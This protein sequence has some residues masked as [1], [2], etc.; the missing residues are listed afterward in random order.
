MRDRLLGEVVEA[1]G[2]LA[3]AEHDAAARFDDPDADEALDRPIARAEQRVVLAA[4]E[5]EVERVLAEGAGD[6]DRCRMQMAA[7][8]AFVE[9]DA[10]AARESDVTCV[11]REPV[12]DVDAR[13]RRLGHAEPVGDAGART[14]PRSRGG[15]HV[16]LRGE[17]MEAGRREP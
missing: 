11:A 5:R 16:D 15:G 9:D 6:L 12:G 7:E 14:A 4:G 17:R 13:A 8:G 3:I 10:Y 1:A 2:D